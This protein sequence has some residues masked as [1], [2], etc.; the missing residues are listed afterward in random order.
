MT[1]SLRQPPENPS[2]ESLQERIDF[3]EYELGENQKV[4]F[5]GLEA[6]RAIIYDNEK[7]VAELQDRVR[8]AER[9]IS[10]L[11]GQDGLH[12]DQIEALAERVFPN[13]FE[14]M[15][16]FQRIFVGGRKKG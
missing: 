13:H 6:V 5:A 4:M 15:A 11:R 9:N 7:R 10:N 14:L 3:L 16:A 1:S 2:L 8:D 12:G